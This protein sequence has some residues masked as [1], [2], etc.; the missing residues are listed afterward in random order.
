MNLRKRRRQSSNDEDN[1][2]NEAERQKK[3]QPEDLFDFSFIYKEFL[4]YRWNDDTDHIWQNQSELILNNILRH[5][6][7]SWFVVSTKESYLSF[8]KS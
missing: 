2:S 1:S 5:Q 7:A 3:T 4:F 6:E 8:S